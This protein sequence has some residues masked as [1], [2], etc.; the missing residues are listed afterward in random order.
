MFRMDQ[1]AVR[2]A[3]G[4]SSGMSSCSTQ[5][6]Q[7]GR[8]PDVE[9]GVHALEPVEAGPPQAHDPPGSEMP[10]LMSGMAT[11][12]PAMTSSS[13]PCSERSPSASGTDAGR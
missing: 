10:S 8:R 12:P 4:R 6:G 11:V 3:A 9:L 1:L 5:A 7:G 13:G 2:R